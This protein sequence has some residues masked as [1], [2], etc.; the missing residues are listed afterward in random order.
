MSKLKGIDSKCSY[1][2][3]MYCRS[4][5]NARAVGIVNSKGEVRN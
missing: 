2:M 1:N 4:L 3:F 5:G